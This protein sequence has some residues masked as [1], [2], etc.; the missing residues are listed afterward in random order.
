[1]GGFIGGPLTINTVGA[2]A[3]VNFGGALYL[4]PKNVSST[5]A[6]AGGGHTHVIGITIS[7]PSVTNT[8]NPDI[9]DQPVVNDN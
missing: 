5:A 2:D 7:A 3:V 8:F 1:M 4:S 6:G 9:V